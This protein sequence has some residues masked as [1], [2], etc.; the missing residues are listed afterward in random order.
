MLLE[1]LRCE[2]SL[3]GAGSMVR[4][5]VNHGEKPSTEADTILA[6]D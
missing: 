1:Q 3:Q 4:V 6:N 2:R 5:L